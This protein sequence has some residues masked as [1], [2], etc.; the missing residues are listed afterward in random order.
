MEDEIIYSLKIDFGD[1][2]KSIEDYSQSI[3]V[4]QAETK[5][6]IEIQ[7]SLEKSGDVL[8]SQYVENSK[9]IE[10]NKQK[11]SE[12]QTVKKQLIV[13]QEA[14]KNSVTQLTA[15]NKLL[16]IERNKLNGETTKG[17]AEISRLNAQLD[18]N[19]EA[20]KKNV[21][22]QEKQKMGVGGYAAAIKEAIPGLSGMVDGIDKTT[23]ASV[24]FITTPI[25][26][27][28]GALGVVV[29]ALTSYFKGSAEGQDRFN[30]IMQVGSAIIGKVTDA[31][32]D[33]VG[34]LID[35]LVKGFEW[36]LDLLAKWVPGF[37]K[38][39]EVITKFLNLDRAKY[40]AD[41]EAETHVL[42]RQL[43]VRKAQLEAIIAENKLKAENKSEDL[44]VRLKF[45]AEAKKAQEELTALEIKFAENKLAIIQATN[46]QSKSTHEA[47]KAEA[48]AE[49]ELFRVKKEGADKMKEVF[50]KNQ[51]LNAQ[52]IAEQ[53]AKE[54]E[55]AALRRLNALQQTEDAKF[56]TEDLQSQVNTRLNIATNFA[57]ASANIQAAITTNSNKAEA[58]RTE[59]IE[60]SNE[61]ALAAMS[62]TA[63]RAKGLFKE[64]T[65]AYKALA[66]FQA[67][68]DTRAAA[69]AAYKSMVGIP[70]VGP[71]LAPIAAGVAIA[72]GAKQVADI[73]GVKF[74]R[75][76]KAWGSTI[77]GK[78]HALGGTKFWGEDGT[79]FEAEQGEGLFVL[80][81]DA[82]A[83]LIS[84]FSKL[85]ESFGGVSWMS[86][87]RSKFAALGGGVGVPTITPVN[88]IPEIVSSIMKQLPPIFVSTQDID[89]VKYNQEV[90]NSF[91]RVL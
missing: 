40:I 24:K 78:P 74:A 71:V 70:M 65:I 30:Q 83:S 1:T 81:R 77:G 17:A 73:N 13:V 66:T 33:L 14:E 37:E 5:D 57:T 36:T 91:G 62:F 87:N 47:L 8:S 48:E 58:A 19:N 15:Q 38:G 84:N 67:F 64:N 59:F 29:L 31:V 49:A 44:Q 51:E 79:S 41:L 26:A 35:G 7:K 27:I 56:V 21:S 53:T 12:Q 90:S 69:I 4:L 80:K 72:F 54:T 20:I 39:L 32:S 3:T 42:E 61:R 6:L 22:A 88:Q 25:G 60:M 75:G 28:I 46:A 86:M 18:K 85:N 34:W 11:L 52:Y 2:Q 50:T 10:I 89:R 23:A 43:I 55:L 68:V 76:G 16:I 63:G 82:H 45:L 9:Q